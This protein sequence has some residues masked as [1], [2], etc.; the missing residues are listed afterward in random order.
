MAIDVI[1]LIMLKQ[2]NQSLD[3]GRMVNNVDK[4]KGKLLMESNLCFTGSHHSSSEHLR[5]ETCM[6]N[7]MTQVA[8]A[9]SARII[10]REGLTLGKH[11]K[12]NEMVVRAKDMAR[13][14]WLGVSAK[15]I[16][17]DSHI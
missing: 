16:K 1:T 15:M 3:G 13:V 8:S 2:M 7:I 17:N 5:S 4:M 6:P 14:Q 9:F 11:W 10:L 12:F